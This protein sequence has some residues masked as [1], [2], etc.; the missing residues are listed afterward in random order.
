MFGP[1]RLLRRREFRSPGALPKRAPASTW[2]SFLSNL[3]GMATRP[4][5]D[6]SMNLKH[7]CPKESYFGRQTDTGLPCNMSHFCR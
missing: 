3:S 5:A 6:A 4:I 7:L 1:G 2:N